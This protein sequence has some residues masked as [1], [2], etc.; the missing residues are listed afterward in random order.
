VQIGIFGLLGLLFV[1]LKLLGT[2]DW[3]WWIVLLPLYGGV[4]LAALF[5]GVVLWIVHKAN[6]GD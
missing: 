1:A 4:V 3:S 6:S 2:I 5:T